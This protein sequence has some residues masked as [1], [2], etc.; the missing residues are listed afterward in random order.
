MAH[1]LFQASYTSDA[2]AALCKK[3]RNRENAIRGVVEELGGKLEGAWM[4][5]GDYD[6]VALVKMP[7]N[8]GAVAMSMAVAAGGA[9]KV[10]KT[11][12]LLKFSDG[13][14]ALKK[15]GRCGYRAPK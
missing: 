5:F 13:V 8:V 7:N 2:M 3:P 10:A 14:S 11:T 6:I 4:S 9:L 12:P 15:A 1:Y